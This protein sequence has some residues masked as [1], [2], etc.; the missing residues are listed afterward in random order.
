MSTTDHAE[1][2]EVVTHDHVAPRH[3]DQTERDREHHG[4]RLHVAREEPGEDH[5]DQDDRHPE[6]DGKRRER[7]GVVGV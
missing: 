4:E 5:V 2:R 6:A 7:L 3:A 1:E